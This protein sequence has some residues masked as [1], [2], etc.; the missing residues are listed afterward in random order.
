MIIAIYLQHCETQ[1]PCEVDTYAHFQMQAK[2]NVRR[3]G[4]CIS[5][6]PRIVSCRFAGFL[7]ANMIQNHFSPVTGLPEFAYCTR[8]EEWNDWYWLNQ[9]PGK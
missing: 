2:K 9:N 5:C 6:S 3:F 7:E 8:D 1:Q 4:S